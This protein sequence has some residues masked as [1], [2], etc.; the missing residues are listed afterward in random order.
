MI[1]IIDATLSRLDDYNLTRDEI[2]CFI[3]LM[4][5]IGVKDIQLSVNVY[6]T[7]DG[8]LPEGFHYY[9]E[10]DTSAYIK[11]I[12]PEK[13]ENIKLYFTPKQ[14][15]NDKEV[16]YYQINSLEDNTRYELPDNRKLMKVIGLDNLILGGCVAGMEALKKKFCFERL[17]LCPENTYHCATAIASLFLQYKGYA[18]LTSMMGIGEYAATEQLI[19]SLH[20]MDR[21]MVSRSF[22][23]FLD[24]REWLENVLG[25]TIS[26]IAPVLGRKIFYV[27][28]GVHVDGILKKPTNYEPYEPELVGL[29]R[30]VT[31]GK[32]SGR[33]SIRYKIEKLKPGSIALERIDEILEDVK[34]M[35]RITGEAVSEDDFIKIIERYE[36]NE[37]NT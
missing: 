18:V 27:E 26:P 31:L 11:G 1:R 24:L 21:Y 5:E 32:H 36:R 19:M 15:K 13:D 28:S 37:R 34:S 17:I 7:M 8:E 35:C 4:G 25:G 9:L 2:Y 6:Y 12:Y 3:E 23:G 33:N 22:R 30:E 29:Q 16:P 20:V 14:C 10:V